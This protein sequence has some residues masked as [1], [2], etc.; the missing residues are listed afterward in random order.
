MDLARVPTA[1]ENVV[2]SNSS[3]LSTYIQVL[4][5][6]AKLLEKVEALERKAKV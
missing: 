3:R 1:L 4:H 5:G 6:S 2:L